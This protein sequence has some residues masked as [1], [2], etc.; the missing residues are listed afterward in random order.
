M[1][2]ATVSKPKPTPIP[3]TVVLEPV[4]TRCEAARRYIVEF[5]GDLAQ[6]PIY[7]KRMST[8]IELLPVIC[9]EANASG[10]DP[11]LVVVMIGFE[12]SFRTDVVGPMGE[13]GIMQV[14]PGRYD[15]KED[16]KNVEYQIRSG[17]R[18]LKEA[19]DECDNLTDAIG[20]YMS[21]ACGNARL[22][23][24]QRVEKYEEAK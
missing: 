9:L 13:L 18:K 17:I 22:Q 6:H 1:A 24:I 15:S 14:M 12:S 23:A 21:R 4:Y 8:A 11:L 7:A 5:F 16:L 3:S 20:R 10:V 2:P 19:L